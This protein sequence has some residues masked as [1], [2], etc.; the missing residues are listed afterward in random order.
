[1]ESQYFIRFFGKLPFTE[2]YIKKYHHYSMVGEQL[3]TRYKMASDINKLDTL[4][5]QV[6]SS[7]N[8]V[9]QVEQDY[10]RAFSRLTAA[11]KPILA[12]G[13]VFLHNR[14]VQK[15]PRNLKLLSDTNKV[16]QAHHAD[17]CRSFLDI[18]YMGS[19]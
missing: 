16:R 13:K 9:N 15:T 2:K 12:E 1:M 18:Q 17:F 8:Y 3:T 6:K 14:V 7:L 11:S 4:A 5:T 10:R 19:W